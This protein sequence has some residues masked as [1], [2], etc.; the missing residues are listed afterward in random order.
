MTD[1]EQGKANPGLH[2]ASVEDLSA[3]GL[4]MDRLGCSSIIAAGLLRR[5]GEKTGGAAL[6]FFRR[7]SSLATSGYR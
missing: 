5:E 6:P 3:R 1:P 2:A 4:P 7:C